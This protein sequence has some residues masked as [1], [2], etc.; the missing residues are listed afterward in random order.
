M[1]FFRAI[2]FALLRE[3]RVTFELFSRR[4]ERIHLGAF[5]VVVVVVVSFASTLFDN[6]KCDEH[7]LEE[8]TQ[9]VGGVVSCGLIC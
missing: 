9:K 7:R 5:G 4:L 6:V 2:D 8:K 3:K 1:G